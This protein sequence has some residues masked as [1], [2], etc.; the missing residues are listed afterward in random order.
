MNTNKIL[1]G[2]IAGGIAFFLLGWLIYG[3]LLM[4][5]MTAHPGTATG[6]HRAPDQMVWWALIAGNFAFGFLLACIFSM[7]ANMNNWMDG[8]KAGAIIGFLNSMAYDFTSYGVTNLYSRTAI[9]ADIIATV[10]MCAIAGAVI[11]TAMNMGKKAS[12]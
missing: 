10:V 4:D 3:V 2:G 5:F 6:V 1:M 7:F 9:G 11:A 8:A 12:A